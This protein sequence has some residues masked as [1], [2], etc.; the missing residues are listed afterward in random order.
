M[1]TEKE[2][3]YTSTNTYSTFNTFTEKTKN[4][5]IVFHGMAYLSKY[6]IK[7]FSELNTE[8]NYI[9]APQA[10]S[11]YYQDRAFKHVGASWL[12][13]ENTEAET[14]NILNYVDAVYEKEIS[15]TVPNLFVLGY[16]QG[17]SI[18]A[19]WVASR[20]IQ[21][22]KL[23]MHSGGIP[24]EL[25]PKDFEFLKPTTEVIYIYGDKDQYVTEAR[26]TEEELK[27]SDLF[28]KRLKIEIFEGIHE[29]NREFL[30]KISK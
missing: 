22:D 21:C 17:V 13:R 11:K 14:K 3:S 5:W 19:R 1:S 10:P 26:K 6:F 24:K 9:I 15:A 12:T 23:I 29:V 30:L 8:E 20:K 27:G 25:Q 2:A 16:S 28:Q 4:V 18:A 7:Y